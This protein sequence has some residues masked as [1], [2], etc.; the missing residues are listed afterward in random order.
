MQRSQGYRRGSPWLHQYQLRAYVLLAYSLRTAP[1]TA[2][3]ASLQGVRVDT[4]TLRTPERS[5]DQSTY[6]LR[7]VVWATGG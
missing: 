5:Y 2:E 4:F 7:R 3:K 6:G 1:G